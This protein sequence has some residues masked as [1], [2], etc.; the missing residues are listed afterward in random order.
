MD[1]MTRLDALAAYEQAW[2]RPEPPQIRAALARCLAS[3]STYRSPITDTVHG[4]EGLA[5]LILDF[6]VMFPGAVLASTGAPDV[7]HD[8]AC[9]G[10]QLRSTARIRTMG[11]DFGM[12]LDGIDVVEFDDQDRISRITAFF[13]VER[14]PAPS[15]A[16]RRIGSRLHPGSTHE[17]ATDLDG[18][19]SRHQPVS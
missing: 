2:T 9:F 8:V 11:L 7:H 18:S 3:A 19:R 6:P 14:R 5:S 17:P 15:T 16:H 4:V 1:I 12:T 13:G 10:W